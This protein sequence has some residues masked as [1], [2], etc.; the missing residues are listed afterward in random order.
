MGEGEIGRAIFD[1][2]AKIHGQ[3][4]DRLLPYLFNE[5]E[6]SQIAFAHGR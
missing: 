2:A 1:A 3:R 4:R 6:G 5:D